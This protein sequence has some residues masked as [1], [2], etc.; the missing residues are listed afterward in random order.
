MRALLEA[1]M[2]KLK[3]VRKITPRDDWQ[4]TL[5]KKYPKLFS[6]HNKSMKETCMCWGISV[7]VGWFPI[8]EMLCEALETYL[9]LHPN[10]PVLEFTQIKEKFGTLRIYTSGGD[11]FT[12]NLIEMAQILSEKICE[13]CGSVIDVSQTE[14]YILTLCKICKE[15]RGK[16]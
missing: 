5:Y 11:E 14:G 12:D 1:G 10:V 4:I 8:I 13:E 9:K 3:I 16:L 7:G 2:N 6:Q 15:K